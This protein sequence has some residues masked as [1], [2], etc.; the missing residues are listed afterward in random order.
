MLTHTGVAFYISGK[1]KS[2]YSS[3]HFY[4]FD[5]GVSRTCIRN[6]ATASVSVEKR[7]PLS[8]FFYVRNCFRFFLC[9][10][11]IGCQV[12]TVIHQV[13]V[14]AAQKS[15]IWTDVWELTLSWW[16]MIC[17]RQLLFLISCGTIA[18]Q[19]VGYQSEWF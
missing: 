3:S 9:E 10:E 14:L 1:N 13:H 4:Q 17:L 18:K 5:W 19:M 16:K 12:R 11:V 15:V 6:A 7:W 2:Q 8:S